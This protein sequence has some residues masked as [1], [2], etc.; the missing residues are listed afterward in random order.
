VAATHDFSAHGA[1]I[2]AASL[3]LMEV[4]AEKGVHSRC[5]IGVSSLPRGVPVEIELSAIVGEA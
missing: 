5:A 1:V 3:L 4:F 2:D